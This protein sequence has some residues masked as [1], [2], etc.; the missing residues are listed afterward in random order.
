MSQ[1]SVN[2]KENQPKTNTVDKL[3]AAASIY[4]A[5]KLHTLA[6]SN[7]ALLEAQTRSNDIASHMDK[8]LIK[9]NQTTVKLESIQNASLTELEKKNERDKLR[10]ELDDYRYQIE[11]LRRQQKKATED[12]LQYCKDNVHSINREVELL[13][14]SSH[15]NV[16]K[17]LLLDAMNES[18][19]VFSA[20]QF[21]QISDKKYLNDTQDLIIDYS[22]TLYKSFTKVE[23][24]DYKFAKSFSKS[25]L[26]KDLNTLNANLSK[27]KENI[28]NLT[29]LETLMSE[30]TSLDKNL[31]VKAKNL[32]KNLG[33]T[34]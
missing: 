31:F 19:S 24:T 10:D 7:E 3:T 33:V 16:E 22:H 9:L 34:L 12:E 6:K 8:E 27:L 25:N 29:Q 30:N 18:L 5:A 15:T 21:N 23:L 32:L 13:E 11:E 20:S 2:S 28:N 14:R 1:I 17:L 4:S 26:N